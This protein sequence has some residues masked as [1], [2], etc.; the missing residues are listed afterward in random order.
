MFYADD[1]GKTIFEQEIK[2]K[3][4]KNTMTD[5]V[6]DPFQSNQL[7]AET[8]P[9]TVE[10]LLE[11]SS[12]TDIQKAMNIARSIQ[13]DK[14]IIE[15]YEKYVTAYK[16]VKGNDDYDPIDKLNSKGKQMDA[17]AWGKKATELIKKIKPTISI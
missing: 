6:V 2:N 11:G 8:S 7:F 15:N 16:R 1:Q 17:A 3:I 12:T 9:A 4:K 10:A 14:K 13:K 5:A